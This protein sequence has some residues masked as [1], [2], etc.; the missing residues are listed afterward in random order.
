VLLARDDED[1][2]QLGD[3]QQPQDGQRDV[4]QHEAAPEALGPAVRAHEDAEARGVGHHGPLEVGD[5]VARPGVQRGVQRGAD[6]GHRVDVETP[7][8]ADDL[9]EGLLHDAAGEAVPGVCRPAGRAAGR[10]VVVGPASRARSRA[11]AGRCSDLD[12]HVFLPRGRR[13]SSPALTQDPPF[14]LHP[15]AR[16]RR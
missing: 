4:V 14:R 12:R 7:R 11:P 1:A 2:V 9:A 3:A 5:E 15:V 13:S 6:V 16:R 8:D 10:D